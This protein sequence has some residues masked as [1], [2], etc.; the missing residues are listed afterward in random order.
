V[1]WSVGVVS[2]VMVKAAVAVAGV[3]SES[4][5]WTVIG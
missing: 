5:T 3:L 2:I 1:T 4:A